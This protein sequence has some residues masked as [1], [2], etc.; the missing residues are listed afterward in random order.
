MLDGAGEQMSFYGRAL[1]W[2]PRT[3]MHYYREVLRLLAEAKPRLRWSGGHRRHRRRDGVD[4][5]LHRRCRGFAGLCGPRPAWSAALTGFLF[6]R[7]N[8]REVRTVGRWTVVVRDG[9]L[10]FHPQGE[11]MDAEEIDA[12][13]HGSSVG[14]LPGYHA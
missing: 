8:T 13:G 1:L 11:A 14:A 5:G 7:M 9:G 6:G 2:I 12:R 3:L 4:V 10:R